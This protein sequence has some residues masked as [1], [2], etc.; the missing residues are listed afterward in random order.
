MPTLQCF[1]NVLKTDLQT[2][3]YLPAGG[4]GRFMQLSAKMVRERLAHLKPLLTGCSLETLRKG[5][6]ALGEVMKA[7]RHTGCCP[8]M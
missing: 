4:K 1:Y 6:N 2:P 7:A 3:I 5:Q 8:G